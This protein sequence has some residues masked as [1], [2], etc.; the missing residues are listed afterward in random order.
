[1]WKVIGSLFQQHPR[2]R[3]ST[4]STSPESAPYS[5]MN[6]NVPVLEQAS[7]YQK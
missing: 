3:A 4:Y 6:H 1:M 2:E 5:Q 7:L